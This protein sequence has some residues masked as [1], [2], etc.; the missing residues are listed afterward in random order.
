MSFFAK[1]SRIFLKLLVEII[2][3]KTFN[4][5]NIKINT[6]KGGIKMLNTKIY[7]KQVLEEWLTNKK[8]TTKTTTYYKYQSVI[9]VN[10]NPILGD[11]V[12]KKIKGVDISN[13]FEDER[14]IS[15]SDST[16]N[17]LLVI[18]NSSI[19]YG[20]D[21]KYRK[22]FPNLKIKIKQPKG[23][24][25][26]L[27][28]KEQ[29]ILEK[30]INDNL[31][32]RNLAILMDLYT[33]LRIGELCA[34][35]WKDIDF[36]NNTISVTKTVQRVKNNDINSNNKTK[37]IIANPKTEHSIRTIPIPKFLIVIL[38]QYRSDEDIYI[39]TKTNKPKDP[40]A[41]EKYFKDLLSKCGIRD[42]VFHSL[43]HTYATRSREAG[44][45]IK[46]LSE[47]L[48]HSTYKITLDIY[49]HTSLD[50]KKDSVNSLV[51]Y[52]KPKSS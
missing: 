8:K 37:L 22:D 16:K 45:D 20:V 34:L 27:T 12:F 10:I 26:Y 38:K 42:L 33:G 29:S 32:L 39:F 49:V 21:R 23:R 17:L 47:L 48:G 44:I 36:I 1:F 19:K 15:L 46:I 13:F 28:K 31:N 40:R 52:L 3:K 9:E 41:L 35:Q 30:Y 50:F 4:I 24:I 51:K 2:H 14:I 25:V 11:I 43:R 6:L 5:K 7:Y 18:I